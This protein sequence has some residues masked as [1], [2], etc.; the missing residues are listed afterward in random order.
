MLDG[1]YF[2]LAFPDTVTVR[3]VPLGLPRVGN[4][5]FANWVDQEV[6]SKIRASPRAAVTL[7]PDL[8]IVL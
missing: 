4:K 8:P 7:I 5:D 6:R 1:V 3:S 2:R